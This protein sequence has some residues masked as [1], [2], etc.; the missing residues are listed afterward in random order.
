[1]DIIGDSD[2]KGPVYQEPEFP[3]IR[4]L[5]DGGEYQFGPYSSLVI[6]GAYSVDKWYRL[7]QAAAKN[8]SFT[9]WF[10][11]EQLYEN[12]MKAIQEKVKGKKYSFVFTHTCPRSYEPTDLFLPM[13]DQSMVDKTMENWLDSIKDTFDWGVWCWAH[14]HQDRIERPFVEQYYKDIENLDNIAKRWTNYLKSGELDWWLEKSPYF[15]LAAEEYWD[16]NSD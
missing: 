4:Y 2:I 16:K 5:L 11:D 1:M 14:F 8:Q 15:D 7:Q 12:E 10:P 9:G 6:G 3:N 13:I